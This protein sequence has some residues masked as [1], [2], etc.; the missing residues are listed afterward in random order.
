MA[1][2]MNESARLQAMAYVVNKVNNGVEWF[3][4]ESASREAIILFR[5]R[6]FVNFI[7]SASL[8]ELD[9]IMRVKAAGVD[10]RAVKY[11]ATSNLVVRRFMNK[12]H[13]RLMIKAHRVGNW[14]EGEKEIAEILAGVRTGSNHGNAHVADVEFS[15]GKVEVKNCEGRLY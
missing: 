7:T 10:L 4:L 6:D 15:G 9:K 12:V 3:A 11:E 13:A 2:K 5:S 1:N 14:E 8:E